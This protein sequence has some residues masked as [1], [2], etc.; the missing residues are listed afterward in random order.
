MRFDKIRDPEND[1]RDAGDDDVDPV[2]APQYSANEKTH[3]NRAPEDAFKVVGITEEGANRKQ[4]RPIVAR[5]FQ[6]VRAGTSALG[7]AEKQS[8]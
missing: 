5:C 3:A 1:E 7:A 4:D 6:P 2:I 8:R